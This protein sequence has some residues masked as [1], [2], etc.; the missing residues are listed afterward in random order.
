MFSHYVLRLILEE[1]LHNVVTQ[2]GCVVCENGRRCGFPV[3]GRG[4]EKTYLPPSKTT[5][6]A[7]VQLLDSGRNNLVVTPYTGVGYSILIERS[8]KPVV[9]SYCRNFL[10]LLGEL[11]YYLAIILVAVYHLHTLVN[12]GCYGFQLEELVKILNYDIL[13]LR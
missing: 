1:Y 2:L 10:N 13:T 12:K 7:F 3:S 5:A 8:Y 4:C 6:K 9:L 11:G